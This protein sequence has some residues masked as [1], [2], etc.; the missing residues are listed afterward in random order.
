MNDEISQDST[1]P[2]Y[3]DGLHFK[4]TQCGN[5]CTGTSGYVWVDEEDI[6]AIAKHLDKPVGEIRLL[7]TRRAQGKM[8]LKEFG[9]GDC[10]Y[11]D[12]KTRTCQVYAVRPVQCRTWPF[13]GKNLECP[14]T[15]E[16]LK[17]ECPGIGK[18]NNVDD[19]TFVSMEEVEA[20]INETGF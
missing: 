10:I 16:A 12:S 11:F 6:S 14:T 3:K 5:C 19:G 1:A 8:S 2:W 13:W 20:T 17:K 9:N 7:H 15:W 4:C 18:K